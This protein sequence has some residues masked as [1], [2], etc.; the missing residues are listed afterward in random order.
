MSFS[1]PRPG[2]G[3]TLMRAASLGAISVQS[4]GEDDE[5]PR[6]QS[7]GRSSRSAGSFRLPPAGGAAGG[8][9]SSAKATML[10]RLHSSPDALGPRP[11]TA[12][13][14]SAGPEARGQQMARSKSF[15]VGARELEY[16]RRTTTNASGLP[17]IQ[18]GALRVGRGG[19]ARAPSVMGLKGG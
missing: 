8:A 14:L 18:E 2:K 19:R 10:R 12:L 1:D 5:E 9:P 3:P 17:T 11:A 6:L 13:G 15:A 16:T 4:D 7:T